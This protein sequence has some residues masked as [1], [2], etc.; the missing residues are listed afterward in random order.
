LYNVVATYSLKSSSEQPTKPA[1][2]D[3]SS[4]DDSN[5][6]TSECSNDS[7]TSTHNGGRKRRAKRIARGKVLLDLYAGDEIN[8]RNPMYTAGSPSWYVYTRI[9]S[10]KNGTLVLQNH[11]RL[12]PNK[13]V[14]F[15]KNYKYGTLLKDL[16]L[17][18]GGDPSI[19][20]EYLQKLKKA[21]DEIAAE[22]ESKLEEVF[23]DIDMLVGKSNDDP[24]QP[25]ASPRRRSKRICIS[26]KRLVAGDD[27][28]AGRKR[29]ASDDRVGVEVLVEGEV[30]NGGRKRK[31]SD[32]CV[33]AE[34]EHESNDDPVQPDASP[35]RRS[36]RIGVGVK[37]PKRFVEGDDNNVGQKSKYYSTF[38]QLGR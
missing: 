36:K 21:T 24:V 2:K 28:N 37:S 9:Q 14:V 31:P 13:N 11:D 30:N 5:T 10:I 34:L 32:D 29:K 4:D 6:T 16:R 33:V 7:C 15:T 26:P 25:D 35:R 8:Y 20:S 27:N 19:P 12:Q 23:K 1:D 18:D 3:E 17:H 38:T 22:S